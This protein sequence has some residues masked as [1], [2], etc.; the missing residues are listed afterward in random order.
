MGITYTVA[1][2][3]FIIIVLSIP[4]R[5]TYHEQM[6]FIMLLQCV[7]F[8]RMRGYPIQNYVYTVFVGFSQMEMLFIP[9]VFFGLFPV[10]YVE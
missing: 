1:A 3:F 4:E 8:L 2:I 9:N 7:G 5:K 6:T 10:S